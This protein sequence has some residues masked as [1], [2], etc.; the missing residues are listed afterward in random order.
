VA[1]AKQLLRDDLRYSAWANQSLLEGCSALTAQELDR[2][3]RI[4]HASILATLRHLYDGERIW[5]LCLRTTPD[6]GA[7]RLP[8]GSPPEPAF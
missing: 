6:L 1:F 7:W 8:T 2:D 3:L 5:L 4:S